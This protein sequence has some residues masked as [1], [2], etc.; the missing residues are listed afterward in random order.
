VALITSKII[1]N[2]ASFS[3]GEHLVFESLNLEV[4]P[5]EVVCV[6]GSNG[7]GKTTLLRCLS[8][9]LNLK[10]G[11]VSLDNTNISSMNLT[12]LAKKVG[13]VFQEHNVSFAYS[14][15]ELVS[16]GR[17]PHLSLFASPSDSDTAFAERMLKLVGMSHLKNKPY[18]EISGGERQ[19]VLIARALAQNPE[20]ILLD[21]PTSHLDF[22]NQIH[23]MRMI[24]ELSHKGITMVL[25]SHYPNHA[26]MF[27]TKVALMHEGR[28][29]AVGTPENVMTEQNLR[30]IYGV[31]VRILSAK[32]ETTGKTIRFCTAAL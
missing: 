30:I 8:G 20:I 31:E 10:G 15:I 22:K 3:Y 27:A 11:N 17:T 28:F 19:L 21:E 13:F 18:T 29:L 7:C 5:G 2:N 4:S 24:A 1:L 9:A 32:D 12:T 26:L 6:L 14:V 16:M 25:T 23:I